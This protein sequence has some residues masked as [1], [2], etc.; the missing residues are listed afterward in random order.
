MHGLVTYHCNV[1][2]P[3]GA[4]DSHGIYPRGGGGGSV[5]FRGGFRAVKKQLS[6]GLER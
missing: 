6:P 4:I 5:G 3:A 2:S 1:D